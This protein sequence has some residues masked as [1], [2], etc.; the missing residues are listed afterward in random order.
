VRELRKHAPELDIQLVEL[1]SV[2]QIE[3]LKAG[4]IDI[5]FGRIRRNDA[6]V[7]RTVLREERLVLAVAPGSRL[8]DNDA[9]VAIAEL[10]GEDLIVYPKGQH[11]SFADQV[12]AL[13]EDHGVRPGNVHEV[14]EMQIALG[15][16]AAATGICVVP[17]TASL[18]RT[19]LHYR[20]IDD[21]HATSPII[22]SHRR[23]DDSPYIALIK[24][25]VQELYAAS[26]PWLGPAGGNL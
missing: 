24:Q 13:L 15:L 1:M 18:H 14:S 23:D 9:P 19:D 6:V 10:A 2:Q 25:L 22:L 4:R 3:A 11:P 7:E 16:A 21:E 26:P 12:L 8:A 5:G 20:V 17:Y